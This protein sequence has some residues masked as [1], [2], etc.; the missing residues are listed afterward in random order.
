M[1]NYKK[2]RDINIMSSSWTQFES[3]NKLHRNKLSLSSFPFTPYFAPYRSIFIKIYH[4]IWVIFFTS[5]E[6]ISSTNIPL[7]P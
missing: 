3:D 7:L 1:S 5:F 6:G 2:S 4:V